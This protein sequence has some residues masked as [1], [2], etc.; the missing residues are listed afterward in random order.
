MTQQEFDSI[1]VRVVDIV[2]KNAP[3]DTGNLRYDAIK[4][5]FK[6]DDEFI[7]YVDEDIAPYMPFTNE[8][9]ED[10]RWKGAKNPNEGW[11]DNLA[12]EIAYFIAVETGTHAKK[13]K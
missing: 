1:C 11:W 5:E 8:K 7:I 4:F 13:K 3:I 6:S 12:K 10:K 2:R 9:W